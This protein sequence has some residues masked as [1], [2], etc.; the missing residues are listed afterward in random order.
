MLVEGRDD[1]RSYPCSGSLPRSL[2]A[3]SHICLT[4][5]NIISDVHAKLNALSSSKMAQAKQFST[6]SLPSLHIAVEQRENT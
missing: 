4:T 5:L 1:A 3:R 6:R 2:I